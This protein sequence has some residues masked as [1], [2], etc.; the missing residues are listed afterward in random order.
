MYIFDV[1][2]KI[3]S[4]TSRMGFDHIIVQIDVHFRRL[5]NHERS[6]ASTWIFVNSVLLFAVGL[7]KGITYINDTQQI[8]ERREK[9][10]EKIFIKIFVSMSQQTFLLVNI[11]DKYF[12]PRL[13]CHCKS[14]SCFSA[15]LYAICDPTII[16]RTSTVFQVRLGKL[17]PSVIFALL[18]IY[19]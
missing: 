7:Q 14:L 10:Q 13:K 11:F 3:I 8:F 15:M 2:C 18:H 12:H 4:L 19:R 5:T 16:S 17:S 9:H 1:K 6:L